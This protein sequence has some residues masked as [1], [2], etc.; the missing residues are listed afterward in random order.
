MR[1]VGG[2]P[3][4]EVPLVVEVPPDALRALAGAYAGPGDERFDVSADGATL[5][6]LPR[7]IAAFARLYAPDRDVEHVE[8]R[9]R[10]TAR[11]VAAA[12][13]ADYGPMHD[14]YGPSVPL[15]RL[16]ENWE[17]RWKEAAARFGTLLRHEVLGLA[18]AERDR[19]RVIV[20]FVYE[21]GERLVAFVWQPGAA[22][23]LLGISLRR[24]DPAAR[25]FPTGRGLFAT[26]DLVTGLSVPAR[27]D[28]QPDGAMHL[29]LGAPGQ[30]ATATRR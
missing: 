12:L 11:L 18:S 21:R 5:K 3:Y 2:Q 4:P 8:Q 20:R 29:R 14:A 28:R 10:R 9:C 17:A 6:V 1:L 27:F 24:F 16:Q 30:E 13:R 19:D 25:L 15:E 26:F 7:G 22:G 23:R